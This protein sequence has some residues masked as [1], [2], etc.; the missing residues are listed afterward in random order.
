MTLKTYAVPMSGHSTVERFVVTA[1]ARRRWSRTEKLAI[2][3]QIGANSVSA[4]AR[5]HNIAPS[6]LFRWKRELGGGVPSSSAAAEQPFVRVAL[7]APVLVSE[8]ASGSADRTRDGAIE[9]VLSGNRRVIVGKSVDAIALKRVLSLLEDRP[10]RHS[11]Q[12]DGG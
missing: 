8:S 2:V 3:G 9:I 7:P 12:S 1:D 4:V 6:L 10:V 5:K 11:S